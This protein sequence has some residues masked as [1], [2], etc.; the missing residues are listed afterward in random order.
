MVTHKTPLVVAI[1]YKPFFH[2][3]TLTQ[4]VKEEKNEC[5]KLSIDFQ[6]NFLS[7]HMQE[8]NKFY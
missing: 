4:K 1:S 2:S 3:F 6:C 7:L 8:I 5:L